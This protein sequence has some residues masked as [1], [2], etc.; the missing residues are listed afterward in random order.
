MDDYH[1]DVAD[2]LP[3]LLPTTPMGGLSLLLR[4]HCTKY[5]HS[6]L[7]RLRAQGKT[8]VL[9]LVDILHLSSAG[10]GSMKLRLC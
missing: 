4:A 9:L 8:H 1:I 7:A 3:I 5:A 6:S 10:H 2:R